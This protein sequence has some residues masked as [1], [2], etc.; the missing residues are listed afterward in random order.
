MTAAVEAT[1]TA[2][3]VATAAATAA[4]ARR[5]AA[6]TKRRVVLASRNHDKLR[7]MRE[8]CEGMPFEVASALDYPGLPEVIE[9]GTTCLGNASRKAIVAAA[10]TGEIAVADDTALQVAALN[11][12]PDIFASRFA[13][14]EATYADNAQLVLDLMRRVPDGHRQARFV[15]AAVWVDPR[16]GADIGTPLGTIDEAIRDGM[17]AAEIHKRWLFN[18]FER[19]IL[20]HDRGQETGLWDELTGHRQAWVE[21]RAKWGNL[22]VAHGADAGRLAKVL[23]RLLAPL[24]EGE[25]GPAGPA[26]GEPAR[27]L[28]LPDTRLWTAPDPVAGA[29]PPAAPSLLIAPSGLPDD[30]PGRAVNEPLW[31]ELS[32]QGRLLGTI[33]REPCGAGGFGYDPI[34]RVAGED[35]TLAELEAGEKNAVSHRG[36]ALRRLLDAARTLYATGA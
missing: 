14:P 15:T 28:R 24:L 36:R 13:G 29:A 35:R 3:A 9:D 23:D 27:A 33:G 19:N 17:P 5:I 1:V 16:P 10:Y 30:A 4:A 21:W 31:L 20:V 2:A 8:L 18:P 12:L 32:A 26:P 34:F 7:E 25:P 11:G 6:V 22:L